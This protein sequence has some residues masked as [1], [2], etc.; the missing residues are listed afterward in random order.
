ME[1]CAQQKTLLRYVAQKLKIMD[2]W[3]RKYPTCTSILLTFLSIFFSTSSCHTNAQTNNTHTLA[4]LSTH[5]CKHTTC[6]SDMV[7]ETVS[8]WTASR[9]HCSTLVVK[10][11][12]SSARS[13]RSFLEHLEQED[14]LQSHLHSTTSIR[15]HTNANALIGFRQIVCSLVGVWEWIRAVRMNNECN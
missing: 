12:G 1:I 10:R 8:G 7:T 4:H 6:T 13:Q 3:W 11:W 9:T 2:T 14:K 15:F 5:I